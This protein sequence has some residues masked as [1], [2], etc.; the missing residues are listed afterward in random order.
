MRCK[1]AAWAGP[2]RLHRGAVLSQ[3]RASQIAAAVLIF[4]LKT[5]CKQQT[6]YFFSKNEIIFSILQFL[7]TKKA[8]YVIEG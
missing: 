4:D 5:C 2:T 6:K 3:K 1:D 8:S 7:S